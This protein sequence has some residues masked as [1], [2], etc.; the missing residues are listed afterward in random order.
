LQNRSNL[1]VLIQ[2][3]VVVGLEVLVNG[4]DAATGVVVEVENVSVVGV[5]NG[6]VVPVDS[7]HVSG[8]SVSAVA[9]KVKGVFDYGSRLRS[10]TQFRRRTY[11]S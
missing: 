6:C 10:Q 1:F 2:E 9:V 3:V 8:V 4:N 5:D 11:Q 7:E